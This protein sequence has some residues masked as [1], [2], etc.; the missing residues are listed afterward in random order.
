MFSLDRW[1]EIWDTLVRNKLRTFL[2]MLSMAWGIFMLVVLLGLGN[3]LQNGVMSMFRDDAVNSIW[4]F[5]GQ[6]SVA[7]E[8]MPIGRTISFK[9][10]DLDEIRK[11]S[12]VDNY[13]GRFQ[14]KTGFGGGELQVRH[15][16]KVATFDIRSVHPGHQ[17]LENTEIILG[18]FLNEAD[19]QQ[20]RKVTVI[21]YPVAEFLFGRRDVLGEW[22]HVNRIPFQIV[23]VFDDSGGDRERKK[24]YVPIATAQAAFNGADRVH[25]MMFTVGDATPEESVVIAK[26]TTEMLAD[27]HS[28]S[29]TDPQAIRV[30]NNIENAKG[31]R[32][33]F[34]AI[35]L[36]FWAMGG[37]A[38]VAGIVGVSNIMMIAVRERTK[39]IGI[40]KALGATPR[41]IIMTIVQEAVVLT[42]IAGYFGLL[43]GVGL[44]AL[45]SYSIGDNPDM[46]F[47]KDPQV[48]F[49]VAIQATILLMFAGSL[50]GFFPARQA[51]KVNPIVALR[52]E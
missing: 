6:T 48:P 33:M 7:H 4:V 12:R 20:R 14:M 23:G 9:N 41:Q 27:R 5:P 18:R 44:L 30:N 50:A 32:M 51:A 26:Q 1:L 13:S 37:C 46:P 36:F 24:V 17:Q 31:I 35:T 29:A 34:L 11:N 40:R 39:E 16:Q 8:G 25:M 42:G 52:D 21:G 2:T 22:I 3:G 49:G 19:M 15:D 10:D 47:F 45:L 38:I 28:F 43:A